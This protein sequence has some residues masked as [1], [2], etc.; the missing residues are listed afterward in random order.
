MVSL[1]TLFVSS[2][3]PPHLIS[4]LFYLFKEVQIWELKGELNGRGPRGDWEGATNTTVYLVTFIIVGV[5]IRCFRRINRIY[6]RC[7]RREYYITVLRER[8]I[9]FLIVELTCYY[10]LSH[11]F[12]VYTILLFINYY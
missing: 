11:V 3:L 9:I 8:Q 5:N 12:I 7:E 1:T 4:I 6:Y 10:L 2:S